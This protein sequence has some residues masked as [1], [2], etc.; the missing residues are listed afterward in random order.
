MS[1][2]R[3]LGM[4]RLMARPSPFG[5]ETGQLP[6]GYFTPGPALLS[7]LRNDS[8]TLIVGAGGLGCE[9]LKVDDQIL[10]THNRIILAC[11]MIKV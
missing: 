2:E 5:N 6:N 7:K 1:E 9:I 11:S 4:T 3:W 8:R 10:C